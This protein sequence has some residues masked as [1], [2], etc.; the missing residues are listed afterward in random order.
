MGRAEAVGPLPHPPRAWPTPGFPARGRLARR[1]AGQATQPG[2]RAKPPRAAAPPGGSRGPWPRLV[3]FIGRRGPRSFAPRW[4]TTLHLV[5]SARAPASTSAFPC[6]AEAARAGGIRAG[7][8]RRAARASP[9]GG[10][11]SSGGRRTSPGRRGRGGAGRVGLHWRGL[12]GSDSHAR[13]AARI[14]AASLIRGEAQTP[15]RREDLG[16]PALPS[17]ER[18]GFRCVL[19]GRPP[20]RA[21]RV[22]EEGAPF[23]PRASPLGRR[24]WLG[25]EKDFRISP[26]EQKVDPCSSRV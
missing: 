12:P 7:R 8:G 22:V 23:P 13:L 15:P 9:R 11:R 25:G 14:R 26:Q 21:P 24:C 10:R 5:A 1:G 17:R 2:A 16:A 3:T 20:S 4:L 6:G 19:P 18:I